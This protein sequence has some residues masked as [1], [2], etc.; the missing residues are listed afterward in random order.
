M[1][2][3][4]SVNKLKH[5]KDVMQFFSHDTKKKTMTFIGDKMTV[6]VPKRF[7]THGMLT[8]GNLV[9]TIGIM[10]LHVD[11]TYISHLHLLARFKTD[12]SDIS[13][14]TRNG[15]E[16]QVLLYTHGDTFIV[17]TEV[18]KNS[19][20]MYALY[21]EFVTRGNIPNGYSYSDLAWVYDTAGPVADANIPV[22]HAIYEMMFSHL[23]RDQSDLFKQYRHTDMKGDYKFV[24][25]RDVAYAPTSNTA[26]SIG[27]FFQ[28]GLNAAV[29]KEEE[30]EYLFENLL[31][32]LPTHQQE[33]PSE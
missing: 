20:T 14:F 31:R 5:T 26:R 32:G 1:L 17:N 10:E 28:E 3:E 25:L 7:E 6:L 30:Q 21:T 9:E 24:G 11:D 13:T 15:I 18:V 27:S 23:A 12:P 4:E 8:L 2:S 22:D 16:Y 33:T 19:R 29:I